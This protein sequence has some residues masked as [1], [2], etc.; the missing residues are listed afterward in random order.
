MHTEGDKYRPKNFYREF[1]NENKETD[2]KTEMIEKLW[3]EQVN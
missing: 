3:K 1:N 2:F